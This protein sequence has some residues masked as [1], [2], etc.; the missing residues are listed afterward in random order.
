MIKKN[1]FTLVEVLAVVA[2]IAILATSAIVGVNYVLNKQRENLATI[3]EENIAQA[4]ITYFQNKKSTH[5]EPCRD[6]DG[7]YTDFNQS[8]V[9]LINNKLRDEMKNKTTDKEKYEYAKNYVTNINTNVDSRITFNQLYTSVENTTCFK[10]VTVGELVDT[11]ILEDKENLCNKASV[12]IVYQKGDSKNA[13]GYLTS[14][15]EPQICNGKRRKENPPQISVSPSDDTNPTG[16]K[17]IKISISDK[18]KAL[19]NTIHIQYAWTT[20]NQTL[21]SSWETKDISTDTK[22]G[23]TT[24][25]KEG[26]DGNYYLWIKSDNPIDKF[27]N[28]ITPFVNGPYTFLPLI[29]VKYNDNGGTGCSSKEKIVIYSKKYNLD[30]NGNVENIC[31]V[32]NRTGYNF[33]RWEYD[34]K[35]IDNNSTVSTK[36]SPHTLKAIWEAKK[37][38][39]T[40]NPNN[41]S[42][43][44]PSSK[45]ITYNQNYGDLC[46]TYRT[47]YTFLKWTKDDD[48]NITPSTIVKTAANHTIT[49]AWGANNYTI[50]YKDDIGTGCNGTTKNVTYDSSYGNLCEP[51][52]ASDDLFGYS[53]DGWYIDSSNITSSTIVSTPSNHTLTAKWSLKSFT[54]TYDNTG[55]SGCDSKT[56]LYGNKWGELCTP[57]RQY[58]EFKGWEDLLGNEITPNTTVERNITAYAKWERNGIFVHIDTNATNAVISQTDFV[59]NPGEDITFNIRNGHT[60]KYGIGNL[61]NINIECNN[62]SAYSTIEKKGWQNPCIEPY[63]ETKK[64][65]H[66]IENGEMPYLNSNDTVTSLDITI[67]NLQDSTNCEVK[68]PTCTY[69]H[70][71][72][73]TYVIYSFM[74][75][76]PNHS[77]SSSNTYGK[78]TCVCAIQGW[79][80]SLTENQYGYLIVEQEKHLYYKWLSFEQDR[81]LNSSWWDHD[82]PNG[83]TTL[84]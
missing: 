62:P 75:T 70:I 53:F 41:G 7:D 12:I 65:Q 27:E 69:Y 33:K 34:G 56:D 14:I 24:I 42:N 52:E 54:L 29:K 51:N 38:T 48:S 26:L 72:E 37:Y 45:Q 83:S 59:V 76:N 64:G 11:G 31:E 66:E 60:D 8:L 36:E 44:D 46:T 78:G 20:N 2:L 74:R 3:S 19:N 17:S 35:T 39:L 18:T 10:L 67:K 15:Q 80:K 81:H 23:S 22:K 61:N 71:K 28:T 30:K 25:N 47:G 58:Y 6:T 13:V 63:C 50:T 5:Q 57:T 84:N 73:G 21:P 43:C 68:L 55:G 82:C 16:T 9:K 77:S 4:A 79:W 32:N 49:A 1:G 40:Y